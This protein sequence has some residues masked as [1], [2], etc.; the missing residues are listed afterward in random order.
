MGNTVVDNAYYDWLLEQ[1]KYDPGDYCY[2]YLFELMMSVPFRWSVPNDDNRAADGI[3]LRYIF[4]EK[5]G[6]NTMPLDGEPC[7]VLEMLIALAR[8]IENDIM[9]DGEVNRTSRWFWEMIDNMGF[10]EVERRD[11]LRVINLFLDRKYQKNGLGMLFPC[12]IFDDHVKNDVQI[13]DQAQQYLLENY[14]F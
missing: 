5:E 9:W 2:D 8:R 4:M 6:W 7:T 1:I 14:E 11:Y 10:S 12:V 3:Q 13:W